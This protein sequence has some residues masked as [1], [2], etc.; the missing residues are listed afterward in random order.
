LG[1]LHP[2]LVAAG[3]S[4]GLV[5]LLLLL[6]PTLFLASCASCDE[7]PDREAEV[8]VGPP[9]LMDTTLGPTPVCGIEA[10]VFNGAD[11]DLFISIEFHGLDRRGR[12]LTAPM[13]AF[14]RVPAQSR[15]T[16]VGT[17]SVERLVEAL[18]CS[19]V[20]RVELVRVDATSALCGA[21]GG[22]P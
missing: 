8:V 16:Y 13:G 1:D 17:L 20:T 10:S 18:P 21:A 14:N 5:V 12:R 4:R 7:G 6:W 9:R 11:E 15:Q 22:L 2:G 3:V 19:D